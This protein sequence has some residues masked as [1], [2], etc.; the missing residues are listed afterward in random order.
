MR[1]GN[2]LLWLAAGAVV[3]FVMKQRAAAA[4]GRGTATVTNPDGTKYDTPAWFGSPFVV[5]HADGS[6][7]VVPNSRPDA[8]Y[9][10]NQYPAGVFV[11]P[12]VAHDISP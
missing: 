4:G 1:K 12:P 2:L 3:Y 8:Y 11:G 9:D 6:K 10:M 7:E 5:T